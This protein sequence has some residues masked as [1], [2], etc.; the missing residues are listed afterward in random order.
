MPRFRTQNRNKRGAAAERNFRAGLVF[1]VGAKIFDG[2]RPRF[3]IFTLVSANPWSEGRASNSVRNSVSYFGYRLGKS[4]F[5]L[6]Q[7]WEPTKIKN[8]MNWNN[9]DK[10]E[11]TID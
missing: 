6:S 5:E 9:L 3:W 8:R 10:R 1:S 2:H 4:G 11:P 7:K